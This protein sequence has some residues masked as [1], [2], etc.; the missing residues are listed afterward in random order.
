MS[1]MLLL[2][3]FALLFL[4]SCSTD[5]RHHFDGGNLT[6][7]FLEESD[8]EVAKAIAF[9][10]KENDLLT[11][12]QQDLQV[13]KEGGRDIV[14]MIAK[15]PKSVENMPLDE[16]QLLS[17]LKKK[18]YVEVFD[19]KAFTLEICNNKFEAIYTVE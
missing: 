16:V 2:V 15:D 18:L 8:A 5:D 11:G 7:Y 6:V 3:G 4:S 1:R 14:S 9:F 19:E 17:Q 12:N 13:R 10:W